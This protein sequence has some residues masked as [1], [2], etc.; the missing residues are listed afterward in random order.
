GPPGNRSTPRQASA[1]PRRE[2]SGRPRDL[3]RPRP[4]WLE[5]TPPLRRLQR[6]FKS[7]P[8]GPLEYDLFRRASPRARK[9]REGA[10][11]A[12]WTAVA[13]VGVVFLATLV[14]SAFGFGE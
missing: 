10:M 9:R 3:L 11:G 6:P 8:A 12:D 5:G 13:V 1:R 4:R 7:P 2:R 14:R